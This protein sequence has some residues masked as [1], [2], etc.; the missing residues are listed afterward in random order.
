MFADRAPRALL[1][2]IGSALGRVCHALLGSARRRAQRRVQEMLPSAEPR[3]LVRQSFRNAGRNLA[4]CL[5]MRRAEP[6]ALD[7]VEIDETAR[8]TLE[9]ALAEKRGVVFVAPHLGPFE[10]IA[11]A[12]AELGH[13][14]VAVVRESY[15]PRLDPIVNRHRRLRGVRVIQRGDPGAAAG[16]VRALRDGR[17]VGFLPDLQSRVPGVA[18]RFLGAPQQFPVGPQR[19]AIR[20]ESPLLVGSLAEIRDHRPAGQPGQFRLEI[21][22]IETCDQEQAMTQRVADALSSAI[23]KS[24][25]HWLWMA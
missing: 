7:L 15:D 21:C 1:L 23:K 20:C 22:R 11:A 17:P 6:A 12:I 14:P 3:G 8:S 25:D 13:D 4:R 10:L 5:L 19:I 2:A 24:P 9:A 18:C 16:I